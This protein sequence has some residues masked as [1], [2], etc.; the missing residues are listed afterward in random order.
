[1][2]CM[3]DRPAIGRIRRSR[4]IKG[5]ARVMSDCS[6]WYRSSAIISK[7]HEQVIYRHVPNKSIAFYTLFIC[8]VVTWELLSGKIREGIH[9][10]LI[11]NL[12][13]AEKCCEKSFRDFLKLKK[14]KFFRSS[15][16]ESSVHVVKR[17]GLQHDE[18]KIIDGVQ[19]IYLA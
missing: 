19:D 14:K 15:K 18:L 13:W 16:W 7:L 11:G 6:I 4:Y 12:N 3:L 9:S 8:D 5:N 1:M 2:L 17:L 10:K